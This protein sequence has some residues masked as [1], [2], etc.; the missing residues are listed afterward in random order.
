MD[1]RLLTTSYIVRIVPMASTAAKRSFVHWCPLARFS[2]IDQC[3]RFAY[4]LPTVPFVDTVQLIQSGTKAVVQRMSRLPCGSEDRQRVV[5]RAKHNK[6]QASADTIDTSLTTPHSP[7]KCVSRRRVDKQ[8]LPMAD[9]T[10]VSTIGDALSPPSLPHDSAQRLSDGYD[11]LA[12]QWA[13]MATE[14]RQFYAHIAKL[15]SSFMEVEAFLMQQPL[16]G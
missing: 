14:T 3:V 2:R 4:D 7:S 10:R 11:L 1:T 16:N 9:H 8:V 5:R 13:Q 15:Q 12:S 6:Q